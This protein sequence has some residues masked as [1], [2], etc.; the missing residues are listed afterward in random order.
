M[1]KIFCPQSIL[2]TFVS[3]FDFVLKFL[4]NQSKY[5]ILTEGNGSI[6]MHSLRNNTL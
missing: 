3:E 1:F 2:P 5:K 4:I 6:L